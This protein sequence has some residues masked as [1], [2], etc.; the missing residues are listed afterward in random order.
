MV[1]RK[2]TVAPDTSLDAAIERLSK[3]DAPTLAVVDDAG[4]LVGTLEDADVRRASLR[5]LKTKATVS[6][7]MDRSPITLPSDAGEDDILKAV[8]DGKHSAVALVEGDSFVEL[9]NV[10]DVSS[11]EEPLPVAVVMAGG[12]GQRLRPLTDK[13]PKPLL[14]VGTT[15]IIERIIGALRDSGVGQIYLSVN[16]KAKAFEEKLGDGEDLGVAIEYLREEKKLGTAGSLALLP[17]APDGPVLVTNADILTRLDFGRLF[18]YHREHGG[19]ATVA[20]V[21]H[22][23]RI[24]YGVLNAEDDRLVGIEEKPEVNVLCNAGIYVLQP[25]VLRYV[26]PDEALD[27]PDLIQ[28][29]LDDGVDV[30]LF[31]IL[32][33]WFDIGSPEDFQRVLIE[34]ATGEE[35]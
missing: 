11:F 31:P 34:F 23:T 28:R 24:P 22:A 26:A 29:L 1:K 15:S 18:R 2:G 20:V 16:Y 9:R 33:R 4:R 8:G 21:H 6:D 5:G 35:E 32:E 17:E 10:S 7:V 3:S 19:P 27:M 13:V 14:K 30:R 12:R 25:E